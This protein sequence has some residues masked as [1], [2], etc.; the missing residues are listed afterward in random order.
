MKIDFPDIKDYFFYLKRR[1]DLPGYTTPYNSGYM[2]ESND[3]KC[4]FGFGVKDTHLNR[5]PFYAFIGKNIGI[6]SITKAS[7]SIKQPPKKYTPIIM[8][9]ITKGGRSNPPIQD[10]ILKGILVMAKNLPKTTAPA[11]NSMTMQDVL[12]VS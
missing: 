3:G 10:A 9:R 6:V 7:A 1:L 2:F 12:R 11:I 4:C 8:V 5:V